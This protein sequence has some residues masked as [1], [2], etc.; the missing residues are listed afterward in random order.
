MAT[1]L[2]RFFEQQRLAKSLKPGQLAQLLGCTNLSKNGSRIRVFEQSGTISR[3]LF[4]K[5]ARYFEVDRQTIEELVELDRREFFQKWL[6]WAN[7]PIQPHL[8]LRLIAAVYSRRELA[9]DVETIKD[10]EEWAAAVA[11]ETALR[12]C[13]VWSRRLS[14][15]FDETGSIS[16]RTE[17]VPNEPNVP[18]MGRSGKTFVLNEDL[19]S[20][21]SVEWPRTPEVKIAPSP[22]LRGHENE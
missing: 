17:A 7:E 12:C 13:L 8:V 18:W 4:E 20:T 1:R 11:R 22:V 10:A 14:I 2:S 6:A 3:E 9:S 21:S 5:L 19:G 16:G 15:W